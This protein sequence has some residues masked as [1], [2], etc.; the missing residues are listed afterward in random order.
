MV[1]IRPEKRE[2]SYADFSC[3]RVTESS[4]LEESRQ[5]LVM[6]VLEAF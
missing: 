5:Q 4:T 2:L 6:Y 1:I 3:H